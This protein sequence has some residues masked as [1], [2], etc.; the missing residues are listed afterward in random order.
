M[1]VVLDIE[2]L[3][4]P[5]DSWMTL[6]DRPAPRTPD[7]TLEHDEA[8]EK[9]KFQGAFCR[10]ICLG[11]LL[12]PQ[13]GSPKA[14]VWYGDDEPAI[15]S[16]FW[17]TIQLESVGQAAPGFQ[18]ITHNGFGFDFPIL[19]QRS[20][21]HQIRPTKMPSLTRFR[22][23]AIY[24]TCEVWSNWDAR[25]RIKLDTLARVL[26]VPQKS[27]HGSDVAPRWLQGA[28]REVAEYC[29]QDLIVTY[30]CF[31]KMLY[32]PVPSAESLL[33]NPHLI[34]CEI[35]PATPVI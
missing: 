28:H 22:T 20:V 18:Y 10:I 15:L 29:L 1:R 34:A 7:D 21:I 13:N 31:C 11:A 23:D 32:Q 14:M 4:I 33:A 27:G 19:W 16:K 12:L 8:Y 24:D 5:R 26:G 25:G 30:S 6:T 3:P 35:P 2:T 9:A 17:S